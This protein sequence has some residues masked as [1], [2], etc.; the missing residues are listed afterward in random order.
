MCSYRHPHPRVR[1]ISSLGVQVHLP[2]LSDATPIIC[3]PSIRHKYRLS[4]SKKD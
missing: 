1:P 2:P 4:M 3:G